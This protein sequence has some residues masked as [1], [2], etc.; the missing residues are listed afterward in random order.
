MVHQFLLQGEFQ[1][2]VS[3]IVEMNEMD[4]WK[5]RP[6]LLTKFPYNT[7][8]SLI[9]YLWH[10]STRVGVWALLLGLKRPD[11]YI[12]HFNHLLRIIGSVFVQFYSFE[13]YC[14]TSKT[15]L[16]EEPYVMYSGSCIAATVM[17]G[18]DNK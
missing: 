13:L 5:F 2:C 17:T 4:K 18:S 12:I 7:L 8:N 10:Q 3:C 14:I 9:Q 16:I 6:K 11:S 15:T 1:V